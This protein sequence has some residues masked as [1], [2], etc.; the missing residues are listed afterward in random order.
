MKRRPFVAGLLSLVVPG[1][2]QIYG[3]KGS[4]GAAIMAAAII[5]G[6]LN[7]IFLVVFAAADP[8]PQKAW[9]YWIPR[10]GHD[11]MSLWSVVFWMWAVVDASVLAKK[12][13]A[14]SNQDTA[15]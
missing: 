9:A 13:Q 7:L 5:I 1:L 8:D 6:N 15:I 10:I 2:G 12:S 14:T 4:R 11:V 3:G